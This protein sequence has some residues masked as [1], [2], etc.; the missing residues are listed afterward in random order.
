[1]WIFKQF[2]CK[3]LRATP[4]V[5]L[6]STT[7][8]MTCGSITGLC[9]DLLLWKLKHLR[10]TPTQMVVQNPG[11]QA[12][13]QRGYKREPARDSETT[14]MDFGFPSLW[15]HGQEVP[16]QGSGEQ[17]PRVEEDVASYADPV[18]QGSLRSRMG[19]SWPSSFSAFGDPSLPC[20]RLLIR[21]WC[22]TSHQSMVF[23]TH[24]QSLV[25]KSPIT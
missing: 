2:V 24:P 23:S 6:S 8:Q 14:V 15:H 5:I 17:V 25:C 4:S 11:N 12:Q 3:E 22:C 21:Q 20:L 1:M 9:F 16:L 13:G 7:P 10:G 18:Q 19:M